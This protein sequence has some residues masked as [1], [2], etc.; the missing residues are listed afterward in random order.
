MKKE[1]FQLHVREIFIAYDLIYWDSIFGSW[2]LVCSPLE[3]KIKIWK[4]DLPFLGGYGQ[5][6]V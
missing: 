4:Q 2:F 3:K 6:G 1:S 5:I